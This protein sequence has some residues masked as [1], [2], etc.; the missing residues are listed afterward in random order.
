MR[1]GLGCGC[2]YRGN[3]ER[4]LAVGEVREGDSEERRPGADQRGQAEH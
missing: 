2:I 4:V 3:L 1:R